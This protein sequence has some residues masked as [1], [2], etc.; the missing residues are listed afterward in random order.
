MECVRITNLGTNEVKTAITD[1]SGLYRVGNLTIGNY[2]VS[3]SR[4][5]FKTLDRKGITLLTSQVAEI[6]AVLEV[7]GATESV[8]VTS[9]AP[10]LQTEDSTLSANLNNEA[11]S[12]LP[13]NVQGSRNLSN[14]MFAYLPGVE[15]TDYSSHING[16][17]A[18][19][20]EVLI[21]GTSAVSQLGGYIS[22]SQPPM[23]AVQE[24]EAD[25]SGIS[26]NARRVCLEFLYG[27][28]G[29]LR[30]ADVAAQLRNRRGAVDQHFPICGNVQT[31]D[32]PIQWMFEHIQGSRCPALS[33]PGI[34]TVT[35]FTVQIAL[36]IGIFMR[37]VRVKMQRLTN[38]IYLAALFP[39]MSSPR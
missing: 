23:E 30:L 38:V 39:S 12:E 19:S 16:G 7:G 17:M 21:D 34:Q 22:E 20:K 8:E 5:G 27:F 15:G 37:D 31:P 33:M 18:L 11:V 3:F 1:G 28:H 10:I 25:T 2:A 32:C 9:A 29:R 13:L 6:D 24:F 35:E 4:S 36:L 26:A 14:F